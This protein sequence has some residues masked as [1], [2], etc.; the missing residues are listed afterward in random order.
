MNA[1]D[2]S[3]RTPKMTHAHFAL[4]AE[5]IRKEIEDV[6]LTDVEHSAYNVVNVRDDVARAFARHLGMTNPRFDR[7]RFLAACGEED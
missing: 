6:D 4:I 2:L 7:A 3:Y 5:I 1:R